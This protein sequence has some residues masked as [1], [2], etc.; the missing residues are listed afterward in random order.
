MEFKRTV[1]AAS[2]A[3]LTAVSFSAAAAEFA[4]NADVVVIGAGGAG[5]AATVKAAEAGAKVITL[6]K[7]GMVGGGA[8]FAEGLYGIETEWQRVQNY[9]LSRAEAEEWIQKFHHYRANAKLN[10][11]F[12]S[13]TGKSLEWLASH[14]L[15]FEAI[16]V[17]PAE[18]LTWHVVGPYGKYHHG[19]AYI[20]ALQDSAK[21][22]GAE[23]MVNTPAQELIMK[24][25]KVAGVKAKNN[26]GDTYTIT[27][28]QV[29]IATGG[30]ADNKDMV[31]NVLGKD[32]DRVKSSVPLNKTGDGIQMAWAVGAD[33]T[34]TTS[35]MHPGTEGKG[36]TFCS[37]V[38]LMAWQPFT[39]WVN[40]R[41]ERFAPETLTFE[42]ALAGN[43]IE[44][45]YG[46]YGWAIFDD[47]ALDYVAEKGVDVGVGVIVPSTA[48]LP[49]IHAEIDEVIA[50]GCETL[51]K[52][53]S[54]EELAKKIN[55]PADTLKAELEKYNNAARTGHDA[56]Y[57]K[58][59]QWMRPIE[60]GNFYAMRMQPYYYATCGGIRIDT[61]MHVLDKNDK[62]IPG[63]FAAGLDAGG[64]YGD[65]YSTWTSGH[66][67]GFASWSGQRAAENA[68]KALGK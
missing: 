35:V 16:Q 57:F 13:E 26:K 38:Y 11:L 44:S 21:K 4:L 10:R 53:S 29:I 2:V 58:G 12:L 48:K 33:S 28:T 37:D 32:P 59:G 56:E 30:F 68:V 50:G 34:S 23:I 39:M 14:G 63:L 31:R 3:L 6:E 1:V 61:D 45:Q 36:I 65:S 43:A 8:A 52:A 25:G 60:K 24:D 15:T 66:A 67:F 27:T 17:S 47:A 7:N 49:K 9:G 5:M 20:H 62:V 51:F 41:G 54:I 46:H 64:L 19:A 22:L 55:V 40:N 42:M 18:T